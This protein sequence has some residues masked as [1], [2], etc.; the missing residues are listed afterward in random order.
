MRTIKDPEV[1][2]NEILDVAEDLFAVKGFDGTSTNEILEKAGIARG[3]LYYHFKSKEDILDGVINRMID[4]MVEKASEIVANKS[5]PVLER[6]TAVILAF[7]ADTELGYE[8][9]LEVHKPQNALMHQKM[10]TKLL[11]SIVP[12]LEDLMDEGMEQGIFHTEFKTEAIEMIILY[13]NTM[14]DNLVEQNPEQRQRRMQGFIYHSE[15]L[16]GTE[17]GTLNHAIMEI[18]EKGGSNK[19]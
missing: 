11:N 13:A 5:I 16:L 9:M 7:N 15:R 6:L 18:F 17:R 19:E 3:T 14:F 1:R 8:V 4:Q 10:Q 2:K 12:I